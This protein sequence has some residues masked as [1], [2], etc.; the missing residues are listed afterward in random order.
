MPTL[1]LSW[2]VSIGSTRAFAATPPR[3]MELYTAPL[4]SQAFPTDPLKRGFREIKLVPTYLVGTGN[5]Y[6]NF[7]TETDETGWGLAASWTIGLS[8]HLGLNVL[9]S[10]VRVTGQQNMGYYLDNPSGP[11]TLVKV[12]GDQ[13][14]TGYFGAVNLLYDRYGGDGFRLPLLIGLGYGSFESTVESKSVGT[15]DRGTQNG[16]VLNIGLSPQFNAWKFR[17]APFFVNVVNLSEQSDTFTKY[18]PATGGTIS[19][20]HPTGGGGSGGFQ[21]AGVGVS[22]KPWNLAITYVPAVFGCTAYSL[23][24]RRTWG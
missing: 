18:N 8:D 24:W 12:R 11:N 13:E 1:L 3:D 17:V 2:L 4:L 14:G 21:V 15:R 5:V 10:A 16:L 20:T 6:D 22:Y 19:E 9:G 7:P 23:S